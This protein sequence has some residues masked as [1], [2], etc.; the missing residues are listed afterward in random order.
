LGRLAVVFPLIFL[1]WILAAPVM[2]TIVTAV[3]TPIIYILDWHD[4]TENI[5]TE[6]D[7]IYFKYSPSDGK[8]V[9]ADY[10][11]LSYNFV[12]LVAL[13]LAVPDVRPRMRMKILLIGLAILFPIQVS[14]VVIFVINHYSQHIRAGEQTLY[15]LIYRK[16]L[17]YSYRLQLL[18][19]GYLT[20]IVIWGGLMFYY[21][22]SQNYLKMHKHT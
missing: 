1:F 2:N 8:P 14:R 18:L 16:F 12:F 19:D 20:P 13:I 3:A 7:R 21:K 6:G 15:P 22:W 4:V 10:R 11:R 5:R 17:F 9:V